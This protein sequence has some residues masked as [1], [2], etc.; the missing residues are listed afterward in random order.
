MAKVT[1]ALA[2]STGSISHSTSQPQKLLMTVIVTVAISYQCG[3]AVEYLC[4]QVM[5]VLLY[6]M[7]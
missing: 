6:L 4:I 7:D 1:C 2:N 3:N 5:V